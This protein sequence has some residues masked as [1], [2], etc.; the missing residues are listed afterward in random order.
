MT[1][2]LIWIFEV[3]WCLRVAFKLIALL[4]LARHR[5]TLKFPCFAVALLLSWPPDAY[6]LWVKLSKGPRA[7]YEASR[8][9]YMQSFMLFCMTIV[10]LECFWRLVSHYRNARTLGGAA[11]ILFGG[12]AGL[13]VLATAGIPFPEW[14]GMTA[15]MLTVTVY[16]EVGAVVIIALSA[17]ILPTLD[18]RRVFRPNVMKHAWILV[19]QLTCGFLGA[20]LIRAFKGNGIV[21]M[22]ALILMQGGSAACYLA[23]ALALRPAGENFNPPP[24][25]ATMQDMEDANR[26]SDALFANLKR[27]VRASWTDW[28]N[29]QGTMDLRTAARLGH[30]IYRR[31]WLWI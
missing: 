5:L 30:S 12:V 15:M 20:A 25:T 19:T 18:R 8:V 31:L 23:W 6:L 11:L 14:P 16:L 2:K 22:S 21:T 13:C 4:S 10:V 1:Q 28:V 17:V 29:R 24:P 7:Y 27:H 9:E 3:L 26:R